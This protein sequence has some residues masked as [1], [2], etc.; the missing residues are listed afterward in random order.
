MSL[1]H[2]TWRFAEPKFGGVVATENHQGVRTML[3]S[4]HVGRRQIHG[5][6][7]DA[8]QARKTKLR[9]HRWGRECGRPTRRGPGSGT[10]YSSLGGVRTAAKRIWF[11]PH[12]P[13]VSE[14][15]LSTVV[16]NTLSV[17]VTVGV[18][19]TRM[20][21]FSDALFRKV[22]YSTHHL[23]HSLLPE[24]T[25]H[26]YH[27]RSRTHSFKLSSQHDERNFIDR[28]LFKNANPVCTQ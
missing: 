22:R 19:L 11:I 14:N 2:A 1:S 10:A 9:R 18:W 7:I 23:I 24:E 13:T 5:P 28:M 15:P 3:L 25:N 12:S 21:K 6:T 16:Y 26:P 4:V 8:Q 20:T 17:L 27:W